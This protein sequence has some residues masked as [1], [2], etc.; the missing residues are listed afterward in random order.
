MLYRMSVLVIVALLPCTVLGAGGLTI[1]SPGAN[2]EVIASAPD[3]ATEVLGDPWDMDSRSDLAE[4]I[5]SQ[6]YGPGITPPASF[7]FT[8]GVFSFERIGDGAFFLMLSPG[9]SS[10]NPLGKNGQH[11]PIDTTRYRYLQFRMYLEQGGDGMV[12]WY[13]GADYSRYGATRYPL[14]VGWHT[15]TI[16]LGAAA[17]DGASNDKR[18]WGELGQATGLRFDFFGGGVSRSCCTA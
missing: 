14:Q 6:D 7:D 3:Y 2:N 15:Y 17:L 8:G 10:T 18:P 11:Y 9:Q 12:Y 16:D 13:T 5:P 4:F 1:D